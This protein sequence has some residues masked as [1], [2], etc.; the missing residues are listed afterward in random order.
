VGD[1]LRRDFRA[2]VLTPE[3]YPTVRAAKKTGKET[4]AALFKRHCILD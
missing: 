4:L 3:F 2:V 1:L